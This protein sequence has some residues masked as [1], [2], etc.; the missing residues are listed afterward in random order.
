MNAI[1]E[2]S[3]DYLAASRFAEES[4][5]PACIA[6]RDSQAYVSKAPFC[7]RRGSQPAV[8]GRSVGRRPP[9]R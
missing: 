7:L 3:P 6:E 5:D 2:G 8:S 1:G 9:G 4:I